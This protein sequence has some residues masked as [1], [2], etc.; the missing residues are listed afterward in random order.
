MS[1][2]QGSGRH[3]ANSIGAE[4]TRE[5]MIDAVHVRHTNS[6]RRSFNVPTTP[7][8]M[9]V[10]EPRR[11]QR[12]IDASVREVTKVIIEHTRK[13]PQDRNSL[14]RYRF[15]AYT[16][17]NTETRESSDIRWIYFDLSTVT[18]AIFVL[19]V[20]GMQALKNIGAVNGHLCSLRQ[21]CLF[22]VV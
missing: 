9:V 10:C 5:E 12:D 8:F 15:P 18:R 6:L 14:T 19:D 7:M 16:S 13:K 2:Y 11:K 4:R 1:A 3:E 22:R 21:D 20:P 17:G